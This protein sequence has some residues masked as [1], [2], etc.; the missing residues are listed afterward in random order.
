MTENK[1]AT[2]KMNSL[3]LEREIAKKLFTSSSKNTLRVE[4]DP[5]TQRGIPLLETELPSDVKPRGPARGAFSTKGQ[6]SF[7]FDGPEVVFERA[8]LSKRAECA[9]AN[10]NP[11]T[12]DHPSLTPH[13]YTQPRPQYSKVRDSTLFS[14]SE[15]SLNKPRQNQYYDSMQSRI[16][17]QSGDGYNSKPQLKQIKTKNSEIASVLSYN[18]GSQPEPIA[19]KPTNNKINCLTSQVKELTSNARVYNARRNQSAITFI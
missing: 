18:D 19:A 17:T 14:Q 15:I 1:P 8:T 16:F 4:R 11:I 6:G 9:P 2:R 13:N 7:K 3:N 5:I 10:R 12:Q